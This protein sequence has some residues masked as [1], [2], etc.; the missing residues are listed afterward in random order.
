MGLRNTAHRDHGAIA[1]WLL[2]C[3]TAACAFAFGA[4]CY[5]ALAFDTVDYSFSI[6]AAEKMQDTSRL[7]S[8]PMYVR[9]GWN[10]FRFTGPD[11]ETI[12]RTIHFEP[13]K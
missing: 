8:P 1:I 10:I 13:A 11:G 12:H 7:Q 2:A 5:R 6:V 3:L 9:G 4:A